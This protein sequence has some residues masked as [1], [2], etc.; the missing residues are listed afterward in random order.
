MAQPPTA[1]ERNQLLAMGYRPED[2]DREF[3]QSAGTP[4][5]TPPASPASA[6]PRET[7]LQEDIVGMTRQGMNALMFGKYPQVYGAFKGEEEAKKLAQYMAEY[8][9]RAGGKAKVAEMAGE[10]LPYVAGIGGAVR[11]A[12]A[13]SSAG[14]QG[15][16]MAAKG[17]EMAKRVPGIGRLLPSSAAAA[18]EIAA[19]E[20][21][22][23]AMEASPEESRVGAALSRASMAL[24]FGK[25][26]EVVGTYAAGKLGPTLSQQSAKAEAAMQKAGEQ[27][28]RYREEA[29]VELT[30]ALSKLYG[31][32][33][34]LRDAVNGM[35]ESLGL[36]AT[37]P[38][39][40]ATAYSQLTAEASPVFR[41]EILTPFLE[42]ID[43]ASTI[44][45]SAGIKA[46]ARAAS[47]KT[48]AEA[49]M[50]TGQYL[51]SG[52]GNPMEVGPEV[53][54]G[55]QMRPFVSPEQ[56]QAAAQALV[57]SIGESRVPLQQSVLRSLLTQTRGVGPIMEAVEQLGGTPSFTQALMQRTGRGL[58][59]TRGGK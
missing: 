27:I 24:P 22:R 34:D 45:L 53:M 7:T 6:T 57:S 9:Q 12:A 13:L 35:A 55:R 21:T 56:R 37:D 5:V 44:P 19:L 46:Y 23:G 51:R 39:V 42:A 4:P 41:K 33:K 47:V 54:V 26:G 40:L 59:A 48:G 17:Y 2:I 1:A 14:R 50:K 31:R 52:V 25:A 36:P 3:G 32:S 16:G 8:R 20:G 18:G 11:G 58:G 49:G 30:P 15:L 29:T 28:N 38:K 10:V 43:Q